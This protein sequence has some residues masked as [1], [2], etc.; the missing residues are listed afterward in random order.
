MK[1]KAITL[2]RIFLGLV[3]LSAGVYRLFHWQGA[4]LEF[5]Q[6][7]LDSTYLPG[8]AVIFEIIGGAFLLFNFQ[9]KKVLLAFI[10]FLAAAIFWAFIVSGQSI[11]S[12]AGELFFFRAN[13]TDLF[14]HFTYLVLLSYL[15]VAR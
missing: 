8:L 2:L 10:I 14:L 4:V 7:K 5:S 11:S 9:T 6:L 3:F 12:S 1:F 13:P 15:L